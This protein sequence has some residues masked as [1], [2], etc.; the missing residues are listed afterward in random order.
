MEKDKFHSSNLM[1][2]KGKDFR[3]VGILTE[4]QRAYTIWAQH[5]YPDQKTF[6]I[7]L[8]SAGSMADFSSFENEP[9]EKDE[10]MGILSTECLRFLICY[11][12]PVEKDFHKVG[13][14]SLN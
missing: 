3:I 11:E 7:E 14:N 6:E 13:V 5:P 10:L 9:L 12:G 4:K 2:F 8:F 1:R